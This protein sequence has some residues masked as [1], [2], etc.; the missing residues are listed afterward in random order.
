[1]S[2]ALSVLLLAGSKAGAG[3]WCTY[4]PKG[5]DIK[6]Q[7]P[8]KVTYERFSPKEAAGAKF[9]CRFRSTVGDLTYTVVIADI[10]PDLAPTY[11]KLWK[12]DKFGQMVE[13][14]VEATAGAKRTDGAKVVLHEFGEHNGFPC[15]VTATEWP[16]GTG[17]AVT[18]IFTRKGVLYV[19]VVGPR[20]SST[21][22]EEEKLADSIDL[23]ARK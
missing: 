18:G 8:G 2:L 15:E 5:T 14:I 7:M 19:G 3:P 23:S 11:E 10:G 1:M 6:L 12:T 13:A 4:A 16:N 21:T 9:A 20:K 17:S 22:D